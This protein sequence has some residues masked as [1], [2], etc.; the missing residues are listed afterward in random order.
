VPSWLSRV[1]AERGDALDVRNYAE[2]GW[3]NW[4]GIVYLLQKLSEGE[5]PDLVV[6]YSGVNETLGARRWP[7]VRRPIWDAEWYSSALADSVVERT[8]PLTRTWEHY[9]DTSLVLAALFPR[10]LQIPPVSTTPEMIVDTVVADYAADKEAV[11]RLG[12]EYGF[13]TM[14]VWQVSVADKA[15]LSAQERTYAGWL[16]PSPENTPALDWW[17]MPQDLGDIYDAIGRRLVSQH[18]VVDVSDAFSGMSTTAFIDWMHTS[19]SGNERVARAMYERLAPELPERKREARE[20][21]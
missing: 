12:R 1:A 10:V 13:S 20:D 4:Q 11:E 21:R 3:V 9:R 6:F 7:R 14:F 8:R 5:R 15:T 16:P 18:G 17:S 2:S 19:E